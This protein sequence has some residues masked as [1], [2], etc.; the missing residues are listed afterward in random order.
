M[1]LGNQDL[2]MQNGNNNLVVAIWMVTYNHEEFLAQAIDSVFMQQA[3]FSYKLFIGEDCSTDKT[4]EI[5]I[6][7]ANKH[8]DK[9]EL[10]LHETNIGATAN[11]QSI[12]KKCFDSGA[13]YLAMT[14]GDDYWTDPLKL[15]KQVDF[16]EKNGAYN[17]VFH[18]VSILKNNTNEWSE[19][20]LNNTTPD[21][22]ETTDLLMRNIIRTCSVV[23][24]TESIRPL[25]MKK[26]YVNILIKSTPGDWLLFLFAINNSK[27]KYL[28]DNM[29]VYR[30]HS[31]GIWS[32]AEDIEIKYAPQL[33]NGYVLLKKFLPYKYFKLIFN[34]YAYFLGFFAEKNKQNKNYLKYFYFKLTLYYELIK[35]KLLSLTDAQNS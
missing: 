18:K 12:Y 3:N 6:D 35:M 10:V 32:E 16:L 23:L 22:I 19:C 2:D 1:D 24:R 11:A 15:Q 25:F 5:C 4:R 20:V 26:K 9:I 34:R 31:G 29:A 13:K 33:F 21:S 28:P 27:M 30:V 17:G 14:E 7:Y 8:P